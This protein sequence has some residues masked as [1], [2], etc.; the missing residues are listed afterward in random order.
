MTD[1]AIDIARANQGVG[2][3]T[4]VKEA[5]GVGVAEFRGR[6]GALASAC[7]CSAASASVAAF[8]GSVCLHVFSCIG[9]SPRL[10]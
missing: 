10:R 6:K 5:S 4:T 9:P 3:R 1:I 2:G 7:K 8:F